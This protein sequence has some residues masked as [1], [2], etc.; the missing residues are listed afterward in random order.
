MDYNFLNQSFNIKEYF[1]ETWST[2]LNPTK[3]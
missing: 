1:N 3:I 2:K